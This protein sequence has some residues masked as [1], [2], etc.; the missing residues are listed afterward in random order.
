MSVA[1]VADAHLNGPGGAARPLVE[2]LSQ[3]GDTDCGSLVF[4]GDLFH[5]WVGYRRFETDDV[6]QV[7]EAIRNLR[8][9]G[10]TVSYVEGNRDFFVSESYES[11]FDVIGTE[12][13]F[14]HD[15]LRY[16]VVHG[17][18]LNDRDWR[19]RFWRSLSKSGPSRL[20]FRTLPTRL[21]SSM[22]VDAERRLSRSNFKHK[23]E[24]PIQAIRSYG[25]RRLAEGYDVLLLGHF[26]EPLSL[27][28]PEG[29]VRI[30]DAWFRCRDLL[31]L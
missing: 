29:E 14:E 8:R 21:A 23:R 2:Q 19:Y 1:L 22:F 30:V 18:G 11:V 16:L 17:D 12:L 20:M 5:T 28:V 15:G 6:R 24:L 10:L 4:L 31:W 3:L 9:Q 25:R 27:R 13:S 26:H 7:I